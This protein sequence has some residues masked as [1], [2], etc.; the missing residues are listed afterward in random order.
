MDSFGKSLGEVRSDK[1]EVINPK[2]SG[3]PVEFAGIWDTFTRPERALGV[4]RLEAF[5]RF[6]A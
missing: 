3:G 5:L 4:G 6:I 1:G 2:R